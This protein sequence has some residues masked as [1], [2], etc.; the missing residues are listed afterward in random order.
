ML[1]MFLW[2]ASAFRR[3]WRSREVVHQHSCFASR[4]QSTGLWRSKVLWFLLVATNARVPLLHS[5]R[6]FLELLVLPRCASSSTPSHPL[7]L[8]LEDRKLETLKIIFF[9]LPVRTV[10]HISLF[11]ALYIFVLFPIK[12][13]LRCRKEVLL[14]SIHVRSVFDHTHLTSSVERYCWLQVGYAQTRI[15]RSMNG[16]SHEEK[17]F[18]RVPLDLSIWT[19]QLFTLNSSPTSFSSLA[20]M[21]FQKINSA[22]E[23]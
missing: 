4:T 17:G 2:E 22:M 8:V 6:G 5:A 1:K 15:V 20:L 3:A 12:M 21:C 14:Y 7:S 10:F 18:F 13:A 16:W 19:G 11:T 23:R 9:W